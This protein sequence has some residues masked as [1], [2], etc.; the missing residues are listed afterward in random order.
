[1]I[2][3]TNMGT[4][5]A[6]AVLRTS[7]PE[8]AR[9]VGTLVRCT[10]VVQQISQEETMCEMPGVQELWVLVQHSRWRTNLSRRKRKNT[11]VVPRRL[12]A[13]AMCPSLS[14]HTYTD[15]MGTHVYVQL[16]HFVIQQKLTHTV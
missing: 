13:I 12:Q 10:F 15:Y 9:K 14:S 1:M 16:T 2:A 11:L 8:I 6:T 7:F 4:T 3:I 5:V